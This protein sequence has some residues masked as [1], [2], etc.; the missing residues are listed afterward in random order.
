MVS[1][2]AA[3]LTAN[4]GRKQTD[5]GT[6]LVYEVITTVPVLDVLL[7]WLCSNAAGRQEDAAEQL[8]HLLTMT[9]MDAELGVRPLAAELVQAGELI[10]KTPARAEV[11]EL[12]APVDMHEVVQEAVRAQ[13]LRM[14]PKLFVVCLANTYEQ[15]GE[16]F[17]VT[18]RAKWTQGAMDRWIGK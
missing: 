18:A 1:E 8:G 3:L 11:S 10:C 14:T 2:L 16:A 5:A 13:G 6:P 9:K 7:R 15:G 4:E 12:A 17:W